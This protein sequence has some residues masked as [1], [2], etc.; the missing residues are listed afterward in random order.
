MCWLGGGNRTCV[1][2]D[3]CVAALGALFQLSYTQPTAGEGYSRSALHLGAPAFP[4]RCPTR[5]RR[6]ADEEHMWRRREST[7]RPH[8]CQ[9]CAL[10]N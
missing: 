6:E 5:L 10:A 8:D 2:H 7:P 1:L 3:L 9:S 4:E